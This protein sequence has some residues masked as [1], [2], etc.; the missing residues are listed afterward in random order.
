MPDGII[1]KRQKMKN[2]KFKNVL[3]LLFVSGF[4][5]ASISAQE[6]KIQVQNTK[7]GKLTLNQFPGNLPIEGYSGNE[8]VI[9]SDHSTKPP[10]R[11]KGLTP[12]YAQGTDNTGMAVAVEKNGNQ[13][14]LNCLLPIYKNANYKIRVPENFSVK[15]SNEC[16]SSGKVTISNV[17]NEVEVKNCQDIIL[18]NV[19]GPL[20]LSTIA[21]D[22]QI[23]FTELSKD[24]PISLASIS[25]EIDVT[26]P[27]K[28]AVDLEME[29]VTGAFYSDFDLTST[30][31][32]LKQVGGS[33]LK[34]QL[35]GGGV[36][37]KITNISGNIYLRKS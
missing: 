6:Y 26:M 36:P 23:V 30:D 28:S 31:K 24:K 2:T 11:A 20:V 33:K 18:K 27:S 3:L 14:T 34:T 8:I 4:L 10:E 9:V 13:I 5:H 12:V 35:N 17:K 21:G 32:K 37:L 15:V 1:I 16:G 29:T 19:T 22:V 25:G 7:E